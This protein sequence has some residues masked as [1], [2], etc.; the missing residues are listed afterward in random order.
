MFYGGVMGT[1]RRL[2]GPGPCKLIYSAIKVPFLIMTTFCSSLPS[3]SVVN[4]LLGLRGDFAGWS[5]H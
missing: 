5:A 2:A 1:Y 4:T 3:F